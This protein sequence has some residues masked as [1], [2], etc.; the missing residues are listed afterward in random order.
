MA[1]CCSAVATLE[2]RA[3]GRASRCSGL[4]CCGAELR[5]R[6]GLRSCG[7]QTRS[8][9][10]QALERVQELRH[11]GLAVLR[12]NHLRLESQPMSPALQGRCLTTGP[13]EKPLYF[14]MNNLFTYFLMLL[15]TL[16][17]LKL[18]TPA[19]PYVANISLSLS[20]AV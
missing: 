9:G 1:L 14:L 5:G 10:L 3:S 7:T 18:L 6:S 16:S 8:W 15:K 13:P 20:F 12:W 4:S 11:T 17:P 2:L 19:L